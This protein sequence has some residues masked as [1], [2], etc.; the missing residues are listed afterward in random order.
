MIQLPGW[1]LAKARFLSA[2]VVC[3]HFRGFFFVCIYCNCNKYRLQ[4]K[5]RACRDIFCHY[6]NG[7]EKRMGR[8]PK[9]PGEAKS[10]VYQLRLTEAEREQ[11]EAAATRAGQPLSTWIRERLNRAANR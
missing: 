8:P 2:A 9:P 11:W 4:G 6:N 10:Q 3:Q 5:K 1:N 7:M